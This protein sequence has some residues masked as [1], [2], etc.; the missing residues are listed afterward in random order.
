MIGKQTW[1]RIGAAIAASAPLVAWAHHTG[2]SGAGSVGSGFLHP[3]LGFDHLIA[4]VAV[5]FFAFNCERARYWV[6]PAAFATA[7]LGG[8]AT[9]A[10]FG[11]R[12]PHAEPLLALSLLAIGV[13]LFFAKSLAFETGVAIVAAAGLLHGHV[14][15]MEIPASAGGVTYSLGLLGATALLHLGGVALA[16]RTARLASSQRWARAG[17]ALLAGTA[18]VYLAIPVIS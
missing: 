17:S 4:A 6:L 8:V 7:M 9:S 16:Q 10:L 12:I 18:F 3:L 13:A 5:G 11:A 15:G 1:I 2:V 14:H